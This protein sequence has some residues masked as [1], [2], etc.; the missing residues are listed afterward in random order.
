MNKRWSANI[1]VIIS[2]ALGYLLSFAVSTWGGKMTPFGVNLLNIINI[3]VITIIPILIF[4][5]FNKKKFKEIFTK[6][7]SGMW[8]RYLLI[9][10]VLW[11]VVTYLN[12]RINIILEKL[13]IDMIEQLPPTKETSA[14]IM[15]LLLTC[16]AAP[17]MEEIFYRGIVL[18]LLKG[19]GN[20]A[21]IVIT[22]LLFALAHGSVSVFVSPLVFGLVLGYI[23]I[24][25]GSVLPA[26]FMHFGC[27]FISWLLMSFDIGQSLSISVSIIMIVLGASTSIW[28][29]VKLIKNK[30]IIPGVLTQTWTY[31]K[32]PL[33]LPVV[34]NYIFTNFMNHG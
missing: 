20:G 9:T 1:Y 23:T 25:E 29:L 21:A 14:I 17:L 2:I 27:N 15:G 31:I 10:P 11:S 22:A 24:R 33:W 30:S 7:S 28:A 13:G 8:W 32:N 18:H 16:V 4:I 6:V 26:I 5:Y 12:S 34:A 19:Y 3:L